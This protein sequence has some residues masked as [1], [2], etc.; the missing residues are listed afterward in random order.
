MI[1]V[2]MTKYE[3]QNLKIISSAVNYLLNNQVHCY[4]NLKL[5]E[6][7]R[8]ILSKHNMCTNNIVNYLKVKD[9]IVQ[10]YGMKLL[11][12]F[13]LNPNKE[14]QKTWIYKILNG[15]RMYKNPLCHLLFIYTFNID[16][17]DLFSG[18]VEESVVE[19]SNITPFGNGPW[20]CLNAVSGHY[21]EDVVTDC[22]VYRSSSGEVFGR[23]T[24]RCGFVYSRSGPDKT[25]N[26][27]FKKNRI[28]KFTKEIDDEISR[29]INEGGLSF[30]DVS[31]SLDIPLTTVQRKFKEKKFNKNIHKKNIVKNK[32]IERR[33]NEWLK[34]MQVNSSLSRY[35]LREK[36]RNKY[37]WLE[38]H[39]KDWFYNSL[40]PKAKKE[41]VFDWEKLDKEIAP[42][43]NGIAKQIKNM[44]N[45]FVR[46]T[47]SAIFQL[48]GRR[49]Y[50]QSSKSLEKVPRTK[51]ELI[52][53]TES[54]EEFQIRSLKI[55]ARQ[56][57]GQG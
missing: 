15:K 44:R 30:T 51:I 38:L 16:L 20:P 7:Y 9:H 6:I 56:L 21:R 53:V 39:D 1:D 2:E 37:Y 5:H 31:R 46:V 26:D 19:K 55:V 43:V 23:F 4:N 12:L 47:A 54:T 14:I 48:L 50:L 24:C 25:K 57:N 49:K 22:K 35:Y 41:S 8:K 27:R 18:I 33:R 42:K 32:M 29:L 17:S 11:N 3:I 52:K 36:F 40:P 34:T 13:F 10:K 28:M 45:P